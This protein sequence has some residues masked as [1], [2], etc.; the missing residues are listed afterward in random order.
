MLEMIWLRHAHHGHPEP[1]LHG[2]PYEGRGTLVERLSCCGA[3][4]ARCIPVQGAS[5]VLG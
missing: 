5:V 4:V 2:R 1:D 3:D